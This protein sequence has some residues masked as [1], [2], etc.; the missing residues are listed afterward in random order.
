MAGMAGGPLDGL[1]WQWTDVSF[2]VTDRMRVVLVMSLRAARAAVLA[3]PHMPCPTC[4]GHGTGQTEDG[5]CGT[6]QGVGLL[7]VG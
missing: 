3:A 2:N 5:R 1:E 4:R 6:C 7:P